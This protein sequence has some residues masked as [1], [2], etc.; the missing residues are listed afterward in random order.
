[1]ALANADTVDE[2]RDRAKLVAS[3]V[4]PVRG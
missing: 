3:R 2:A 1:V 4:R